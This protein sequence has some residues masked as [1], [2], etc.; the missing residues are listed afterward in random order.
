MF[1][2]QVSS[3]TVAWLS[4]R[5]RTRSG[6]RGVTTIDGGIV[7]GGCSVALRLGR[8]AYIVVSVGI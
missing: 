7:L 5:K 6:L 4:L 1:V 2:G 8:S 3:I